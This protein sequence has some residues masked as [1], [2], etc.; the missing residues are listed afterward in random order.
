MESQK[1]VQVSLAPFSP[2]ILSRARLPRVCILN[3]DS[4]SS[5]F[6]NSSFSTKSFSIVNSGNRSMISVYPLAE[7]PME[8][9]AYF[10]RPLVT[11]MTPINLSPIL[12]DLRSDP[13]STFYPWKEPSETPYHSLACSKH[14]RD[15]PLHLVGVYGCTIL[16][17]P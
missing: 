8:G 9:W 16:I 17:F 6:H 1:D 12:P 3:S 2:N 5:S 13:R 11:S 4:R 14:W 10:G 15:I 7:Y